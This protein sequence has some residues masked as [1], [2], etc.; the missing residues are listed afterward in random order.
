[1]T[2]QISHFMFIVKHSIRIKQR[3]LF[4]QTFTTTEY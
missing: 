4:S 2:R 1:M 3:H